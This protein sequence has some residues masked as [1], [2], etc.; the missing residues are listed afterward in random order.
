MSDVEAVAGVGPATA[1]KLATLD[2]TSA[3]DLA[4]IP[5]S[6]LQTLD[7]IGATRAMDLVT[8]AQNTLESED[9]AAERAVT[10]GGVVADDTTDA[11]V[12]PTPETPSNDVVATIV[13]HGDPIR[14][15]TELASVVV[16]ELRLHVTED[17]LEFT[18][19]DPANVGMV[20]A[21]APAEGFSK[22]DVER[23]VTVGLNLHL[24]EKAVSWARK[25]RSDDGDPVRIQIL[26]DPARVR[27]Q[28]T[29]PDQSVARRTEWFSIDPDSIRPE[30]DIPDLD[31][32]C[33]ATPNVTAL[34][35]ATGAF[36]RDHAHLSRSGTTMLLGTNAD[37]DTTPDGEADDELGESVMFP[38]AAH[39]M[40]DEGVSSVFSLDYLGDFA[41]ALKSSKA[42]RVTIRWGDQFPVKLAFEHE[43]WGFAGEFML[44]P[45]I[46]KEGGA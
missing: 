9:A 21:S 7:G 5:L 3:S 32:P 8:A 43:D 2:I 28:V 35:H 42:D 4:N 31:L 1:R 16:D 17:G 39:D 23:E 38:N 10:D 24:F 13:T 30:P 6:D 45:R 36:E 14:S 44:A 25:G 29:R 18:A 15:L 27:V 19:V 37:G 40:G 34:R 26:D 11:D 12:G 41:Q 20:D 46:Q 22:F 33:T